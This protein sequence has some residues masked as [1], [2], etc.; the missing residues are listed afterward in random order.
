M[1]Y[2]QSKMIYVESSRMWK[3]VDVSTNKTLA[4][5]NDTTDLPVGLN[6]WYFLDV[7]CTDSQDVP[8]RRLNL[9]VKVE[10]PGH[11]CCDTGECIRI[12]INIS[13]LVCFNSASSRSW[14]VC[15]NV[16]HC[17]DNS[18][19]RDCDMVIFPQSYDNLLPPSKRSKRFSRNTAPLVDSLAPITADLRVL[20]LLDIDEK[21]STFDLY[22]KLDIQWYDVNVKYA[23][24]HDLDDK[25]GFT[26]AELD[27]VNT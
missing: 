17:E 13:L 7:E 18:D 15:D 1:G 10:Q 9:H 3:I 25:N 24:L 19:E 16:K 5:T 6:R 23:Y 8:W 27:K 11:F 12:V 14:Q 21:L 2:I 4:F 20:D 22:F 26:T